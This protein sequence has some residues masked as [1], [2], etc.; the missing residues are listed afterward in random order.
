MN[1]FRCSIRSGATGLFAV[2]LTLFAPT[3]F[4]SDIMRVEGVPVISTKAKAAVVWR[5]ASSI[6]SATAVT[7]MPL[8]ASALKALQEENSLDSDVGLLNAKPLKIGVNRNALTEISEATPFTLN[9]QNVGDGHIARWAVTS[10][11]AK[12]MRVALQL[13]AFPDVAE[14][15]F[16]GSGEPERII[17]VISGKEANALRDDNKVYWT[18]VTEGETQN[19]EIYLPST[20]KTKDVKVR[21]NAVSHLFTSAQDGFSSTL[22]TKASASCQVDVACKFDALGAAFQNVSKAV[23]RMVTTDALYSYG[24]SG[25]LLSDAD[26]SQIPYFWSANHCLNSEIFAPPQ[27]MANSLNTHWFDEAASCHG[28]QKNPS[29]AQLTGGAQILHNQASTDTLLL[30]LNDAPPAGAYF[31]G[32]DAGYF[33]SGPFIG[34]H[35]PRGDIKKVSTGNGAGA[36]CN[37]RFIGSDLPG[38]NMSLLSLVSWTEGI[39]ESGSSGSGLFTLSGGSYHLRGGLMGGAPNACWQVGLPPGN[40]SNASCYFSLS[41]VYDSIKQYLGASSPN[42]DYPPLVFGPAHNYSGQWVNA[43]EEKGWGLSVLMAFNDPRYIFVPWYTYDSSGRAQWYLFQGPAADH[44]DWTANDTFEA[45]V[46]RYTGSTWHTT[47]WNNNSFS[48]TRV[49]A[50]KLT[51]TSARTA[52]FEYNIGGASR[53]IDLVKLE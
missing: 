50:A 41:L 36:T 43:N 11:Q 7:F 32:W 21:L 27:Q 37:T 33:S 49:G 19:I 20:I 16:S 31:A 1:I 13:R 42:P 26:K 15:R 5:S 10:P 28:A 39:V 25:T 47:P 44:G 45:S 9:W 40:S 34:V 52:R 35:H 30:K 22:V 2:A 23:A 3:V 24:C 48:G 51:F 29:Y 14:L 18:P 6:S 17:G 38:L 53:T 12:G 8:P 46:Y 4:S